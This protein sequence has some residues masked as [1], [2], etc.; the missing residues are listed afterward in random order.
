LLFQYPARPVV[1][2]VALVALTLFGSATADAAAKPGDVARGAAANA[3]SFGQG[4]V[5]TLPI[6]GY[7]APQ[8]IVDATAGYIFM[9][10]GNANVIAVADMSGRYLKSITNQHDVTD[11]ALS[12]DGSTLYAALHGADEISAI[13]TATLTQTAVYPTGAGSAPFGLALSGGDLWFTEGANSVINELD[14]ATGAVTATSVP[15]TGSS[16]S[17]PDAWISAS[18]AVPDVLVIDQ[19]SQGRDSEVIDGF[20]VSTGT[21]V[22][23]GSTGDVVC[24]G[25]WPA[26]FTPDGADVLIPCGAEGNVEVFSLA[27]LP[28]GALGSYSYPSF[29]GGTFG[30]NAVAVAPDGTVAFGQS[31][32]ASIDLFTSEGS[33]PDGQLAEPVESN[34]VT[35][36]FSPDG[37]EL[38]VIGQGSCGNLEL[39]PYFSTADSSSSTAE[40]KSSS[41]RAAAPAASTRSTTGSASAA[42]PAAAQG[43]SVIRVWGQNAIGTAIAASQQ[44]WADDGQSAHDPDGRF[45][46]QAVVLSRSNGYYDA[47]AGSALAVDKQAP[48]LITP[49]SELDS[50]VLAEIER[51]IPRSAPV[52]LLGGT[53]ALSQN[54]VNALTA[55][56]YTDQVRLAG[57]NEYGTDVAINQEI[58]GCAEGN[59][60]TV[61]I[62]TGANYEDALSAGAAAGYWSEFGDD[63]IV[64]LTDGTTIPAAVVA[65]L[66]GMVPEGLNGGDTIDGVQVV[67]AGGPGNTAFLNAVQSGRLWSQFTQTGEDIYYVPL[68]GNIAEDTALDVADDFFGAPDAAAVATSTAWYD[69]LSGGAMIGTDGGPLLLTKPSG[70]YAD[71][72]PYLNAQSCDGDLSAVAVMGG[73][74]ALPAPII[75]QIG[76]SLCGTVT[77]YDTSADARTARAGLSTLFGTT[78]LRPGVSKR[79]TAVHSVNK[80]TVTEKR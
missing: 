79:M 32:P 39:I 58:L 4:P 51:I 7:V 62:A 74:A 59:P 64:A 12:P 16:D 33:A 61:I 75:T 28:V 26:V 50:S 56:G 47:L 38:Y 29:D 15:S 42:S 19:Q 6:P 72:T 70:L 48:L 49:P 23:F 9:S 36:A 40:L 46:A 1:A 54:V 63:T 78:T 77:D 41:S 21:P 67:T 20:N 25:S 44:N 13:D 37:N 80:Q 27:N 73:P 5:S 3:P 55:A 34:A 35:L 17:Y 65:Y 69:A 66:N 30:A 31:N 45:Q 10:G 22:T 14:L 60:L 2:A 24:Y 76:A 43:S 18:P 68:V 71:D 8:M 57:A 11:I 52:Y 53:A